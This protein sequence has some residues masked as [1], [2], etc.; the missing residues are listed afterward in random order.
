M[1]DK[2]SLQTISFDS[3]FS[4]EYEITETWLERNVQAQMIE[5]AKNREAEYEFVIDVD[6]INPS[7]IRKVLN[8][9]GYGVLWWPEPLDASAPYQKMKIKVLW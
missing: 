5:R 4:L 2:H 8:Y 3:D 6:E 9:K 1:I 7:M